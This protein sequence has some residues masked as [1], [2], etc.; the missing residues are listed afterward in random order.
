MDEV[1]KEERRNQELISGKKKSTSMTHWVPK[2]YSLAPFLLSSA[3]F[4]TF[5]TFS[6]LSTL[7]GKVRALGQECGLKRKSNKT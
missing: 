7:G 1:L 4:V 5:F 3:V 2:V 6:R